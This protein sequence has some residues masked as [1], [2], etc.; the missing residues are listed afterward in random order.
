MQ[1]KEKTESLNILRLPFCHRL[2]MFRKS[3]HDGTGFILIFSIFSILHPS[4]LILAWWPATPIAGRLCV[5]FPPTLFFILSQVLPCCTESS[6]GRPPIRD[7]KCLPNYRW[8]VSKP[9]A[10]DRRWKPNR[11]QNEWK[12][13]NRSEHL[14]ISSA[15]SLAQVCIH[16]RH[17]WLP[18]NVT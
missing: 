17:I 15:V 4:N 6:Q 2:D 11:T 8:C 1:R 18:R 7:R 14:E 3:K 9:L 10:L 5:F 12:I 16:R 13:I